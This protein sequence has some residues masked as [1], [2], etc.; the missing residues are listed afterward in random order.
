MVSG[1]MVGGTE[2]G[3][4]R[5]V[6]ELAMCSS[7]PDSPADGLGLIFL[8]NEISCKTRYHAGASP[9][10][11]ASLEFCDSAATRAII[12]L[13]RS[14]AMREG[15]RTV[16]DALI[17]FIGTLSSATTFGDAVEA[18]MIGGVG[19]KA[20]KVDVCYGYREFAAVFLTKGMME[21]MTRG[22]GGLKLKLGGVGDCA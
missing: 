6:T 9:S 10:A 7:L 16:M 21:G 17:S 14:T 11:F 15:H 2:A 22:G 20:R 4:H 12:I 19:G 1:M 18:C 5:T 3:C 8:I 13:Q